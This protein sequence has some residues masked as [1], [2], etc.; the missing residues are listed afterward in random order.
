MGRP[1]RD[2]AK[3]GPFGRLTALE[4]TDKIS[5]GYKHWLCLCECGNT[6]EVRSSHLTSGNVRSCGCLLAEARSKPGKNATHGYSS[7][8]EYH[9]YYS[10]M[11]RCYV[12]D[13]SSYE[14]YGGR[15]ITVCERWLDDPEQFCLDMGPRPDG[16]TIDR[17]DSNGIYEP[18]NCR[19]AT[20][21]EQARNRRNN[22][23]ITHDG[24]TMT[25]AE[26][27]EK[28]GLSPSTLSGRLNVLKWDIKRALSEPSRYERKEK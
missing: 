14:N 22:R 2:L 27:A 7:T 15:G 17:I 4:T 1:M 8:M 23:L 6:T 21:V 25:L 16:T 26:W 3:E 13:D 5:R 11:H 10:M 12:E 9:S 24:L 20:P 19:W 18:S 28:I